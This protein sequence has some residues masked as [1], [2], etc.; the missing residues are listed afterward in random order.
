MPI[1]DVHTHLGEFA[2]GR[3]SASGAVLCDML[4]VAGITRAIAFSAESC[5]GGVTLGNHYTFQ[6]VLKHEMLAMLI[7]VH[8]QHFEDSRRLL[9]ELSEHP[10]VVGIKLHPHHGH[11]H[12]L[13]RT[14]SRLIEQEIAPR[15]LPIL[16]HVANDSPN[17]TARDFFELSKRFPEQHFIGAHLGIGVLGNAQHAIDAWEEYQPQNV[18][19]DTGTLRMFHKGKMETYVRT[20]GPD[21]LCFGTDSPLYTPAAFTRVLETLDIDDETRQKIAW[22]NA[23]AAFPKLSM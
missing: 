18:W 17:V 8:P 14:L 7:I 16:S 1:I 19:L 12:I 10:K 4:R 22:K 13:D 9:E 15:G 2:D 11:Y 21:R 5:Y 23:L 6:E 20:V 3:Q